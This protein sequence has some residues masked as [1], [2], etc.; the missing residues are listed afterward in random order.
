M[1]LL[2]VSLPVSLPVWPSAEGRRD[3]VLSS[4]HW[5][6]EL[7]LLPLLDVRA[8]ELSLVKHSVVML[9]CV[10]QSPVLVY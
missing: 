10:F 7:C 5:V 1:A 9:F 8:R 6:T 3:G 2:P 4:L